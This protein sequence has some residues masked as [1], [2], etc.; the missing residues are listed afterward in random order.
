MT[1][2]SPD[3]L[4][5]DLAVEYADEMAGGNPDKAFARGDIAAAYIIGAKETLTR[6]TNVIRE[7]ADIGGLPFHKAKTLLDLISHIERQPRR[8]DNTAHTYTTARL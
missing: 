1:E 8:N 6:V 3:R 5:S 7:S 2:S 4:I